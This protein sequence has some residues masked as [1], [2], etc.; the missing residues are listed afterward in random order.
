MEINGLEILS[1]FIVL[2]AVIDMLGSMPIVV[3]LQEK[4]VNI[5]PMKTTIVAFVISAMFMYLG[6]ATLGLF[7]VD[8]K[9]FSVAGA[10]V[11]FIISLEMVCGLEIFKQDSPE[12]MSSIV[13][14]AFPLLSG[15]GTFTTL[16]SLRAEY[17]SINIIIALVLNMVWVYLLL[18]STK[19]VAKYIGAGGLYVLKKFFG[20]IVLAMSVK[21]FTSN[22]AT[23]VEQVM[24]VNN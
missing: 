19:R 10:I 14:L 5:A 2:F 22:L 4:G 7:G 13:P 17:S 20:V 3:S 11:L 6:E 18:S 12:G 1:S 23:L 9:S 21:L 16:L 24:A 15:P 8:L